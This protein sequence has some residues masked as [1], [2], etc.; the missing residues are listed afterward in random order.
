[1]GAEPPECVDACLLGLC[2]GNSAPIIL[3]GLLSPSNLHIV[4]QHKASPDAEPWAT[5]TSFLY[6][7][8]QYQ[9]FYHSSRKWPETWVNLAFHFLLEMGRGCASD[10]FVFGCSGSGTQDLAIAEPQ[11]QAWSFLSDCYRCLYST[12]TALRE[13]FFSWWGGVLV[14]WLI[15]RSL[16]W[17]FLVCVRE[18]QLG[19]YP[20]RF[21]SWGL[22]N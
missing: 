14:W 12:L 8:T 22:G 20:L 17:V 13:L 11:P 4:K 15:Q 6:K 10:L 21:N 19:L 9:V 18:E 1:M 7:F 3:H 5:E 2:L 16:F